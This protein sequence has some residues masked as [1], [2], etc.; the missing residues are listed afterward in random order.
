[1]LEFLNETKTI[2]DLVNRYEKDTLNLSP[3]F[4]R[5]SVWK[6]KDRSLLIDSLVRRFPLPA[7]FLYRR[8]EHGDAHYDVIDGKQRLET[9][10]RFMGA[11]RG[12]F[13]VKTEVPGLVGVQQINAASLKR[14]RSHMSVLRPALQSYRLPVVEVNGDLGDIVELFV[15]INSTGKPLTP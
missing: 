2:A 6:D 3:T 12:A 14:N 11:M 1:M 15:R 8:D 4:Q 9:I 7:I 5:R 13:T 10:L